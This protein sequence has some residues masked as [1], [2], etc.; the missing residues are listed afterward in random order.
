MGMRGIL[1]AICLWLRCFRGYR[2]LSDEHWRNKATGTNLKQK[3]SKNTMRTHISQDFYLSFL[4]GSSFS[5][6]FW[7]VIFLI[8]KCFFKPSLVSLS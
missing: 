3:A 8:F 6:Y 4:R 2:I 1:Y 5:E 7:L